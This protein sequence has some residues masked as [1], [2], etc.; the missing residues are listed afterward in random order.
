MF[1]SLAWMLLLQLLPRLKNAMIALLMMPGLQKLIQ[2]N[3]MKVRMTTLI[4]PKM[5]IA[6]TLRWCGLLP[7][8]LKPKHHQA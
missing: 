7:H 4:L 6:M 8:H 5:V 1:C 2:G 3:R